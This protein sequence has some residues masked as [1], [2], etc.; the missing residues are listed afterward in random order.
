MKSKLQ[1]YHLIIMSGWGSRIIMAATQLVAIPILLTNLGIKDYAIF[2]VLTGLNVWFALSCFGIGP[3]LQNRISSLK[4][5]K[6]DYHNYLT[7]ITLFLLLFGIVQVAI[8]SIFSPFLQ[9]L[10]LKQFNY[11]GSSLTLFIIESIYILNTVFEISNK[12][13]FAEQKGYW[14][15][16]YNTLGRIFS[17]VSIIVVCSANIQENKL[18]ILIIA[19][20]FTPMLFFLIGYLHAI[21]L[22]Y[23]IK[24][25]NISVFKELV[26]KSKDF[27]T[28]TIA[29][30]VIVGMDYIV[31]SQVLIP[32]DIV[33]YNIAN[34]VFLLISLGYSVIL[35]TLWPVLSEK[36]QLGN[37]KSA[38]K[39]IYKNISYGSLLVVTIVL[40]FVFFR[41]VFIE[42][43][44][45]EGDTLN[46]SYTIIFLFGVYYLIKIW[47]ETFS[48]TLQ[49]RN[50]TKVLM[51]VLPLQACLNIIFMFTLGYYFKLNGILLSLI[52]CNLLTSA[53]M[54]PF[55]HYKSL[56]PI[57]KSIK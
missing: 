3:S 46:I 41:E 23:W 14:V 33:V 34:K 21:P 39:L 27:A 31:I 52:L 38:H 30:T 8:F 56:K 48:I 6:K 50:Q 22:S 47:T 44:K 32:S 19:W 24:H 26:F 51:Y 5:Q 35:S 53:Y 57:T 18:L 54:L 40:F 28:I 10:L 55:A 13:F 12:I 25:A 1:K 9:R 17:L 20:V 29:G 37:I 36:F 43:F 45:I 7:S 4:V 42:Y 11:S 2:S 15:Y 49:S 16:F